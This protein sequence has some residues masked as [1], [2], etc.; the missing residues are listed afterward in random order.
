LNEAPRLEKNIH[1]I[2]KSIKEEFRSNDLEV[3]VK[4]TEYDNITFIYVKEKKKGRRQPIT[5]T[6]FAL[7]LGHKYFFCSV[8]TVPLYYVKAI[9]VSLGY[10]NSKA[11][12]LMGKDLRSLIKLLWF[13]QQGTLCAEYVSQPPVYRPSHPIIR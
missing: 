12:K 6:F 11:I 9:A 3:N 4:A 2:Q 13:K 5:P 1:D 8:K 7:F 10:K